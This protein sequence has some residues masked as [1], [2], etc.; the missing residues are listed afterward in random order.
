M[1][2]PAVYYHKPT[3]SIADLS[4]L[5]DG[6][7]LITRINVPIRHRGT[8]IGR[9]ILG[10]ILRDADNHNVTLVLEPVASGGLSQ[11]ALV[12]WYKRHGFEFTDS[13]L[14]KRWPIRVPVTW[15]DKEIIRAGET[16]FV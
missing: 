7:V 12:A 15:Q 14:M 10:Q 11:D 3:R 2:L 4:Q 13:L 6:S 16:D 5:E 8:G 1:N 9:R